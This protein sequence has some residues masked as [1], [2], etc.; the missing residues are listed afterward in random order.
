MCMFIG[1][2]TS[3]SILRVMISLGIIWLIFTLAGSF[4][5]LSNLQ[6]SIMM[7]YGKT[8]LTRVIYARSMYLLRLY[9]HL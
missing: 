6:D 3:A 5:S 1:L 2:L 9:A 8:R 7:H 4:Y